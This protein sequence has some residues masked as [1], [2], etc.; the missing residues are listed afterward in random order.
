MLTQWDGDCRAE[1]GAA[2][3]FHCFYHQLTLG[4]LAPS[5]GPQLF[6]AYVEILNQSLFPIETILRN[7]ASPW[8]AERPRRALAEASLLAA[9]EELV[10]RLGREPARWRWGDLHKLKLSHPLD[11]VPGL[12]R[13]L[14]L[15]PFST[16]GDGTTI[17]LGFFRRSHPYAHTAGPSLRMIADLGAPE[18][19]LFVIV[20]GQSGHFCSPHY[21]DQLELWRQGRYI[22]LDDDEKSASAGPVLALTPAFDRA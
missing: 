18:H 1:S 11:A 7:P 10:R 22:R 16:A 15:A 2:A 17:N 3:L 8:F 9:R 20:P 4:L 6:R 5:L 13:L 21:T 19:S 12:K 14:S